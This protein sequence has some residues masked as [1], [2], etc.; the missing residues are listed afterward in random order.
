MSILQSVKFDM[1]TINKNWDPEST[2]TAPNSLMKLVHFGEKQ[3]IMYLLIKTPVSICLTPVQIPLQKMTKIC[4]KQTHKQM[5]IAK[6]IAAN[7][8]GASRN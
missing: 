2:V 5:D 6:K 1:I 3:Q 4:D 8:N 7:V